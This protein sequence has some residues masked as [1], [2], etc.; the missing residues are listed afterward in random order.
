MENNSLDITPENCLMSSLEK[1]RE[2][3]PDACIA[4]LLYTGDNQDKYT[5]ELR[6]SGLRV[7]EMVAL[8]EIQKDRLLKLL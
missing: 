5:T 8:L 1:A 4:I 6:C 7:S 2:T 3:N